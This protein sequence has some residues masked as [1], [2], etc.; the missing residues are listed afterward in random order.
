MSEK[1]NI[2]SGHRGRMRDKFLTYGDK[3]FNTY[4]L[5]EMLL[6]H[7]IPYRDTNPTAKILMNE[8]SGIGGVFSASKE[9]LM[10]IKGIGEKAAEMIEAVGRFSAC[11][12]FGSGQRETASDVPITHEKLGMYFVEMLSGS[13]EPM[14]AVAALNNKAEI[15]HSEILYR[16]D[17][18]FAEIKPEPFIS[19]ALRKKASAV[20]IAHTHPFGP[21]YPTVS[22]LGTT[23]LLRES[24]MSVGVELA[25]HYI[26]CGRLFYGI[27][28]RL[29]TAFYHTSAL[30]KE[31][32]DE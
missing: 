21:L 20:A 29:S 17:F 6:Y 11:V 10:N 15:I 23:R 19:F 5:L 26:I 27:S 31:K 18:S 14:V 30:P 8:F 13:D 24:L 7:V 12:N 2:H 25:E 1:E 32:K 28:D 3:V 22:D 9:E 4:E 16:T